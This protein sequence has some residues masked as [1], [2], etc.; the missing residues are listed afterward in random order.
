MQTLRIFI[1]THLS[2]NKTAFST[3]NV[4]DEQSNALTLPSKQYKDNKMTYHRI[5]L[6]TIYE[7]ANE[8]FESNIKKNIK[9]IFYVKDDLITYEWNQEYKKENKI[10]NDTEDKD[11]YNKLINIDKQI[12]IEIK[13][14]DAILSSINKLGIKK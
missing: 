7:F 6:R 13:G 1:G 5:Q 12:Q 4:I 14:K 10:S 9:L 3:I 2:K 11:I 8:L